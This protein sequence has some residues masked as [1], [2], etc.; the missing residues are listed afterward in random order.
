MF[1]DVFRELETSVPDLHAACLVGRDGIEIDTHVREDLP[2]EVLSAEMNGLLR[3]LERLEEEFGLGQTQEMVIRTDIQNVL[4][5]GLSRDLFVLTITGP[6]VATG[7][8]RYH[9]QRIAHRF[10]EILK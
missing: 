5:L 2:H 7:L 1:R 9:V 4:I 6:S 3:N 10:L 8:A